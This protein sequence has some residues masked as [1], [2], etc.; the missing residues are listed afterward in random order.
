MLRYATDFSE[1]AHIFNPKNIPLPTSCYL[2]GC[3]YACPFLPTAPEQS[4]Q[5]Y[6]CTFLHT[7]HSGGF[8][9][10]SREILVVSIS[11]FL[12]FAR[13]LMTCSQICNAYSL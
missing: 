12:D 13:S 6:G 9:I 2:H 4:F 8:L 7:S 11:G 1:F 3:G 5:E 10:V